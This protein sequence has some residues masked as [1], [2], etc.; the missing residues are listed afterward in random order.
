MSCPLDINQSQTKDTMQD[1]NYPQSPP[2]RQKIRETNTTSKKHHKSIAIAICV[3]TILAAVTAYVVLWRDSLPKNLLESL[4][5]TT[6]MQE[7]KFHATISEPKNA[8]GTVNTVTIDGSSKKGA[9]LLATTSAVTDSQGTKGTKKSNWVIDSKGNVYG[10][11]FALD[12]TVLDQDKASAYLSPGALEQLKRGLQANVNSHKDAWTKF[13]T[14]SLKYDA[15]YGFQACVLTA[16]YKI[17]TN[18]HLFEDLVKSLVES[19][20]FKIQKTSA[21]TYTITPD[22]SQSASAGD[23]YIKSDLYK[24][25]TACSK[26]RYTVSSQSAGNVLGRMSAT[27]TIDADAKRVTSLTVTVRN[28]TTVEAKLTPT[29]GVKIVVPKPAELPQQLPNESAE[30]YAQRTSPY[31]YKNIMK[32]QEEIKKSQQH[33]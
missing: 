15:T 5:N 10:N 20:N 4:H 6:N 1:D 25:L 31:L 27:L 29:S 32:M 12:F 30:S 21:D 7:I 16:F 14:E 33:E 3:V 11:L 17:Q 13:T 18:S 8:G 26:S 19:H 23:V 9:G 24:T 28:G 22:A 2:Q